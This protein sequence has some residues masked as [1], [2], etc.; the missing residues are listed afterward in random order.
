[1]NVDMVDGGEAAVKVRVCTSQ[2]Y[3]VVS[4]LFATAAR[5]G[6]RPQRCLSSCHDSTGVRDIFAGWMIPAGPIVQNLC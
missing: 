1:M 3:L 2:Y 5:L 4:G 6:S